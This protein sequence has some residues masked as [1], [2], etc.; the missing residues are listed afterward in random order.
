MFTLLFSS[1]IFQSNLLKYIFWP[2]FGCLHL[3]FSITETKNVGFK[4]INNTSPRIIRQSKPKI[5]PLITP[6]FQDPINN[7]SSK[8]KTNLI[9][10]NMKSVKLKFPIKII[11]IGFIFESLFLCNLSN[12][13][14][15]PTEFNTF[16]S[17]FFLQLT[18]SNF[19]FFIPI[20]TKPTTIGTI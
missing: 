1:Y 10:K 18:L 6:I 4:S 19:N 14:L 3:I 16:T 5:T 11:S 7:C 8:K 13:Y 17:S 2:F 9:R 12:D 15:I 20:I